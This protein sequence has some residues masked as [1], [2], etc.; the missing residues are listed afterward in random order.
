[1]ASRREMIQLSGDEIRDFF[2]T[3][4]T[5]IIVSNGKDGYPHV[6]PMWFY[7]DEGGCLYVTT[8]SKSQKVRNWRRDPKASLLL[9]SGVEYSELKSVLIYATTEIIDDVE[10]V[11]DTLVNIN[12][13]GRELST[14]ER[15]EL[16]EAVAGNAAKRV[17]LKFTPERYV[18]WDHAKLGGRY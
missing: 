5:L 10:V 16:K 1:M 12:A 13:K 15:A 4:K 6:M 8:F 2:D 11:K 18:T 17:V 9:E 3:E 14:E 7:R